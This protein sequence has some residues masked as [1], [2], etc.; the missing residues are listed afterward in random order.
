MVFQDPYTS[1]NP[2]MTVGATIAEP[3]RVH[4]LAGRDDAQAQVDE[5]L[6]LVGSRAAAR[7]PLPARALRRPAP[8]RRDRARAS[9][10]QPEL[11]I[12]DEASARSTSRCRR[13]SSTCCST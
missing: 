3:L 8:A 4:G 2:R 13:R 11:L 7:A 1:L 6:D 5:L 10:S 9:R 12:A